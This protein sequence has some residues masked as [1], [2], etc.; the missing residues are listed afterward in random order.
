MATATDALERLTSATGF[1]AG[2][3]ALSRIYTSSNGS[4]STYYLYDGSDL[5]GEYSSASS[6]ATLRR[7]GAGY[8]RCGRSCRLV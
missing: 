8:S 4:A 7:Y 5:I 1:S 6:A 2:Y 3:D